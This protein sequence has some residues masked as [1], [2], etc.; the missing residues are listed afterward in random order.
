MSLAAFSEHCEVKQLLTVSL[1]KLRRFQVAERAVRPFRAVLDSPFFYQ[2]SGVTHR[3]EPVFESGA[4]FV[5]IGV[6]HHEN[7]LFLITEFI[8]Q[9]GSHS[10]SQLLICQSMQ[11]IRRG[12][13]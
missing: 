11:P 1:R 3:D 5:E 10:N 8:V 4:T 9:I 2:A 12:P 7:G 6:A 13:D